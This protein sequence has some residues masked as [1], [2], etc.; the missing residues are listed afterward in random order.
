MQLSAVISTYNSA[1]WLEKVFWGYLRQRFTDFEVLIA[2][3]GSTPETADLIHDIQKIAYFPI[4]HI[5]Q[6][7]HGFQKCKILNRAII[8]TSSEYLVFSDGNCIPRMDF[9]QEHYTNRKPHHFLS[10]G[11]VRLSITL[12]KHINPGHIVQGTAFDRKWLVA[13]GLKE[14]VF[15]NLKL[16]NNKRLGAVFNH[17]SPTRA[18]WNGCNSSAWKKDILAVNGFDERMQYG[19]EDREFGE[20]LTNNGIRGIKIRYSAVCVHLDHTRDYLDKEVLKRN[21]EIRRNT[22]QTK[23]KWTAFGVSR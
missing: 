15:K 19:A 3:D 11:L 9:L 20:R 10:A 23:S 7:D 16:T 1:E 13:N 8:A 14:A 2:D 18:T 21:Q 5:W 6:Q 17:L 12:S 22:K 4:R